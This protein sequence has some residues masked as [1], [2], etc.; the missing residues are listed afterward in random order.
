[1]VAST[2]AA[3]AA[4]LAAAM[5]A[6]TALA[7]AALITATTLAAALIAATTL[8]AAA[9]AAVAAAATAAL[10][11]AATAALV[12]AA[13][14]A[15]VAATAAITRRTVVGHLDGGGRRGIERRDGRRRRAAR[16]ADAGDM[17]RGRGGRDEQGE[18]ERPATAQG[19]SI[20]KCA[21]HLNSMLVTRKRPDTC[22]PGQFRVTQD[23]PRW[24]RSGYST[25][26]VV[27]SAGLPSRIFVGPALTV[28][29]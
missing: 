15:L 23:P 19:E 20:Q 14:A 18:P 3:A 16:R 4:A 29:V 11:A 6:A 27:R 17:K 13:T 22:P 7:A 8:A 10:V 28:I 24:A 5:V 1:L 25:S 21:E 2:A 12:A 9:T 26:T